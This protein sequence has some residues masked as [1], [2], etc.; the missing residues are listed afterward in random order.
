MA[1]SKQSPNILEAAGCLGA[2]TVPNRGCISFLANRLMIDQIEH[3]G[4]VVLID[5]GSRR[6]GRASPGT[7]EESEMV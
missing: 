1:N 7:T 4:K 5:S 6:V 2:V 3:G